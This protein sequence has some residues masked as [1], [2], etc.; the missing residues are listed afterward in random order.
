MG[1]LNKAYKD[2]RSNIFKWLYDK[3]PRSISSNYKPKKIVIFNWEYKIGD[4]IVTSFFPRELKKALPGCE[5]TVVVSG[6]HRLADYDQNIDRVFYCDRRNLLDFY[7]KLRQFKKLGQFD[8][9]VTRTLFSPQELPFLS[10]ANAPIV[11]YPDT[12]PKRSSYHLYTYPIK[13]AGHYSEFFKR[14]VGNYINSEEQI[15]DKFPIPIP[16]EYE[17]PLFELEKKQ[18]DKKIITVNPYGSSPR[19]TQM[20]IDTLRK[21]LQ[22]IHDNLQNYT[23]VIICPPDKKKELVGNLPDNVVLP[24]FIERIEHS[25]AIIKHSSLLITPDTF[26]VHAAANYK[27]P[28]IAIFPDRNDELYEGWQPN[29]DFAEVIRMPGVINTLDFDDFRKSLKNIIAKG[30]V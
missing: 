9:C 18:G 22:I 12:D 16:V 21:V 28:Q 20:S 27:I 3:K 26:A 2:L 4:F 8:M 14:I 30:L 19:N 25:L 29:S 6:Y 24:D 23:I 10:S 13:Q 15:D 1:K 17:S 5:I 11:Y 7:K